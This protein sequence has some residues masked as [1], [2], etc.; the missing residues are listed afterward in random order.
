MPWENRTRR[1]TFAKH[2]PV[3]ILITV[4]TTF[5]PGTDINDLGMIRYF[6]NDVNTRL[7]LIQRQFIMFNEMSHCF[8]WYKTVIIE[9]IH[10]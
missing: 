1:L 4:G 7:A 5:S 3:I 10:K 6:I 2:Y 9:I 8:I